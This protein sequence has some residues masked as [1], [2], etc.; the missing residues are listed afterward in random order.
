MPVTR[1]RKIEVARLAGFGLVLAGLF[2]LFLAV[3]SSQ[4]AGAVKAAPHTAVLQCQHYGDDAIGWAVQ[5]GAC[6][7]T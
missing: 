4:Q 3:V 7:T 6:E 1:K 5:Q 2:A